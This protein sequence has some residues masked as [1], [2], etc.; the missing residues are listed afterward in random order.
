MDNQ[1]AS[2]AQVVHHVDLQVVETASV[3][4]LDVHEHG[5]RVC[6]F[7][8]HLACDNNCR[9][10]DD[11]QMPTTSNVHA[12]PAACSCTNTTLCSHPDDDIVSLGSSQASC[13][14]NQVAG[15]DEAPNVSLVDKMLLFQ[16]LGM[17]FDIPL[18]N[19]HLYADGVTCWSTK[20]ALVCG[21]HTPHHGTPSS[22]ANVAQHEGPTTDALT[23]QF[24]KH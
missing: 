15:D 16:H 11:S 21:H 17:Q 22:G 4:E 14:C 9:E 2:M 24:A 19:L 18:D 23:S 10:T 5:T 12:A 8:N 1:S 3:D 20:C 13:S 6:S 7:S